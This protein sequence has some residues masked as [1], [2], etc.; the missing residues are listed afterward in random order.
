VGPVLIGRVAEIGSLQ[1]SFGLLLVS[2]VM[3]LFLAVTG[4]ASGVT[5][6]GGRPTLRR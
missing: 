6:T 5:K 4:L 1:T 2:S 3:I